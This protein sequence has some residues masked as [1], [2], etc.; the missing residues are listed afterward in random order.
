MKTRSAGTT[1]TVK[2]MAALALPEEK[3]STKDKIL[4]AAEELFS[5]RGF[6]GTSL[7]DITKKAGVELAL[8]NYHFGP[9]EDLFR[10]VITR[11]ADEHREG[12]LKYLQDAL[13]AA[14]SRPPTVEAIIYAFCAPM[15]EKNARGGPGW[16]HYIQLL[17][18]TANSPQHYDFLKP[19][20]DRYDPMLEQFI[21][22]LKSAL[23]A[24]SDKNLYH[25]F[26]FLQGT[27]VYLLSETGGI[28]RI[29]QGLCISSDFDEIL[30]HL[31]PFFASGFY[32]L[33]GME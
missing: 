26:Y 5:Q 32:R 23:P 14:G 18:H 6:Y 3:I 30:R 31:V 9:K 20:N 29:S 19:M 28:D 17:S 15:F 12:V 8:A 33:A 2:K 1:K 10:Q 22:A 21:R 25:S 27:I 4:D 11:R 13:D 7:R 16:K 24:C